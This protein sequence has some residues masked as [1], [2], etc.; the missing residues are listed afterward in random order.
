M[1]KKTT[2]EKQDILI[3]VKVYPSVREKLQELAEKDSRTLADFVRVNLEKLIK[4][5]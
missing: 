3:Q 4:V 1:T 2:K 5:E